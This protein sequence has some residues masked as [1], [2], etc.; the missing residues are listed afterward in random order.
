[1]LQR[2]NDQALATETWLPWLME[3]PV[4]GPCFSL[5]NHVSGEQG[6]GRPFSGCAESLLEYRRMEKELDRVKDTQVP[7]GER[8]CECCYKLPTRNRLSMTLKESC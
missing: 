2:K 1:M 3:C 6:P 7:V 8:H 4:G 5:R